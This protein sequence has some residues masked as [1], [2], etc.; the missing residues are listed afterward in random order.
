MGNNS[1]Q[2]FRK[3]SLERIESPEKVNA[4]IRVLNPGIW[5]VIVAIVVAVIGILVW[6]FSGSIN[7]TVEVDFRSYGYGGEVLYVPEGQIEGIDYGIEI[8]T[9]EQIGKV[10]GWDTEPSK[11]ENVMDEYVMHLNNIK[12]NDYVYQV[13]TNLMCSEGVHSAKIIVRQFKPIEFITGK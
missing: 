4:F 2:L 13:R 10:T 5:I 6:A 3:K 1:N 12:P 11:A 9:D 8:D 7:E